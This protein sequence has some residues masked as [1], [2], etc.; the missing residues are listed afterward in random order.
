M[1]AHARLI[2]AP[3]LQAAPLPEAFR[4]P[5]ADVHHYHAATLGID[6]VRALIQASSHRPISGRTHAFIIAASSLTLEAQNAL[7]KLFEEPP[8]GTVF[9]LIIPYESLLIDT[10]RSRLIREDTPADQTD[11]KIGAAFLKCDLKDQLEEIAR[12]AKQAP[13]QLGPLAHSLARSGNLP[14]D[15]DSRRSLLL[16]LKYV[17]NRGA[18][19]KMLLEELALSLHPYQTQK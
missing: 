14:N 12:L 5:S 19:R 7:L 17:Y 3:S 8:I 4:Q 9:Y 18:A 10:L 2:I 13:E 11:A 1:S 15:A 6:E 16:A